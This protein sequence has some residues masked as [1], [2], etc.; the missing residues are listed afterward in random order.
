MPP[1]PRRRSSANP[2]RR[3]RRAERRNTGSDLGARIV[4]AIPLIAFAV[5]IVIQGGWVWTI[6][7]AVLGLL[8]VHEYFDLVHDLRPVRLAGLLTV[9]AFCIAAHKGDQFQL[10]AIA[11]AAFP[12][13]FILTLASPVRRGAIVSMSATLMGTFWI[14]LPLAHAILLRD[15]PHGDGVVVAVLVATFIGDTGAYLGGRTFGERPLAPQISPNKTLEGVLIGM[16]FAVAGAFFVGLYQ[17]WLSGP[18]ALVLGAAVAV[19]APLG[20]L[21][22]SLIKRDAGVKG[23]RRPVRR[24]RRRARPPRR[25]ALHDRGG[26]LRL[27][28]DGLEQG[29]GDRRR[30]RARCARRGTGASGRGTE[31]CGSVPAAE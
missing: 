26:L 20:D 12:V 9:V 13:T 18:Q 2:Q 5:F 29:G 23:H 22:E 10:V 21:F 15:L 28:G 7:L 4:A 24:A 17:D 27:G 31:P 16:L 11:A 14:G 1:P 3:V 6:A 25:G 8:C 30:D 19:T